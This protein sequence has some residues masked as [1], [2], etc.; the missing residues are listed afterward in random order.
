MKRNDS[1]KAALLRSRTE[2]DAFDPLE[3]DFVF[4]NYL[5]IINL[6]L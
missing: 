1:K 3:M 5:Q 4:G 6:S 2:F